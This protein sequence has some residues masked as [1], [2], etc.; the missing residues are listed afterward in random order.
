MNKP[1][2]NSRSGVLRVTS[3]ILFVL[4]FSN[5]CVAQQPTVAAITPAT[6]TIPSGQ[7]IYGSGTAEREYAYQLDQKAYGHSRTRDAKWYDQEPLKQTLHVKQFHIT[8]TPITNEQYLPFVNATSHS[9]PS[10]DQKTWQGY[11]LVHPYERT[12]RH[13]WIDNKPPVGREHH[14]VVLVSYN[15]AKE[16]AAWLTKTTGDVWRLPTAIEW[17]KASRGADGQWFPWGNEF[18]AKK[19]NSHDNGPFD[20]VEAGT[21]SAPN[22]Y[23]LLDAAGQVF[24][25]TQTAPDAKRAWVKGGSW[26]DKGCGVC[27][28]AARHARPITLKH[29]LIGFRLIKE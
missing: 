18:D 3:V 28:P 2:E 15:E 17:E 25:W 8:T 14:P 19:L 20:T 12:H 16:Y 23:G 29:I 21:M 9:S 10:V 22:V 13:T 5:A 4:F 24:E 11:G 7:F 1:T 6:V 26:D 27:R